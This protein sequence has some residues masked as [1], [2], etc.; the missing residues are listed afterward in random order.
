MCRSGRDGGGGGGGGEG[1]SSMVNESK[2]SGGGG[3]EKVLAL[4]S[5]VAQG[6]IELSISWPG[7]FVEKYFMAQPINFSF[8]F[9]A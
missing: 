2:C 9:K 5:P 8:L 3:V 4:C 1:F 7:D 6:T